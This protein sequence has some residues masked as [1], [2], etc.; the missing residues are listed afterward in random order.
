MALFSSQVPALMTSCQTGLPFCANTSEL[1]K[2]ITDV[3]ETWW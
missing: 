3:G 2:L 1:T